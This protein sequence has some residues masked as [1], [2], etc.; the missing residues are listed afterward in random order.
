MIS[1]KVCF[2]V[3]WYQ[4]LFCLWIRFEMQSRFKKNYCTAHF[5][6]ATVN[7]CVKRLSLILI[8]SN[9]HPSQ[10]ERGDVP[11]IPNAGSIYTDESHLRGTTLSSGWSQSSTAERN[12]TSMNRYDTHEGFISTTIRY[13]PTRSTSRHDKGCIWPK[14]QRSTS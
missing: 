7:T 8:W 4:A 1:K 2:N 9:L 13:G 11:L 6:F 5:L 3:I 14:P 12:Y 10:H